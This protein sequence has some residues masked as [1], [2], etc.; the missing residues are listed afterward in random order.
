[1][2]SNRATARHFEARA[3]ASV[4]FTFSSRTDVRRFH[5]TRLI[6]RR[7]LPSYQTQGSFARRASLSDAT[8]VLSV[9]QLGPRRRRSGNRKL[10]GLR[11]GVAITSPYTLRTT[12]PEWA[13]WGGPFFFAGTKDF[14][15]RCTIKTDLPTRHVLSAPCPSQSQARRFRE[16]L[17]AQVSLQ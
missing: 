13:L 9:Q 5:A 14:G 4:L 10:N 1:M 12:I 16:R 15:D 7:D 6:Y 11:L 3:S 8:P 2:A 17:H